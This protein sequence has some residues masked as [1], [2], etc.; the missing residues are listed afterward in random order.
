MP[1]LRAWSCQDYRRHW[2]DVIV[3]VAIFFVVVS[4]VGVRS[5]TTIVVCCDVSFFMPHVEN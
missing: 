3:I 2:C 1:V 5:K 4:G